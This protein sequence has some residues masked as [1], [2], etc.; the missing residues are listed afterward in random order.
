ME[1]VILIR[2][3]KHGFLNRLIMYYII[4]VP[5]QNDLTFIVVVEVYKD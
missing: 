4:T 3:Y 1:T 5:L 2:I